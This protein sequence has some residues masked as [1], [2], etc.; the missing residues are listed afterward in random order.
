MKSKLFFALIL[1][2]CSLGASAKP[3]SGMPVS[4]KYTV[5]QFSMDGTQLGEW[6][7]RYERPVRVDN[8]WKWRSKFAGP[9]IEVC[10]GII[11]VTGDDE[12]LLRTQ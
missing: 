6:S 1:A 5:K 10:G 8:C 12:P 9:Y 2:V 11:Q 3:T 4:V 7:T